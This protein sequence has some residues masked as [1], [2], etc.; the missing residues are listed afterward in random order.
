MTP[1]GGR[2][3]VNIRGQDVRFV[4]ICG[5]PRPPDVAA[6][7]MGDVVN[8]QSWDGM[9]WLP[10]TPD[11]RV[12][13]TLTL[14]ED[15]RLR[16]AL[17]G[18]LDSGLSA[19]EAPVTKDGTTTVSFTER[20]MERAGVY[21]RVLGLVGQKAYTLED[22]FQA[23]RSGALFG[24]LQ[25]QRLVVGQVFEGVHFEP[26]EALEFSKAYA[27][28][29]YLAYWVMESGL[30]ESIEFTKDDD[31]LDQHSATT[32]RVKPL[33]IKTCAAPTGAAVSLGQSYGVAG[34]NVLERKLTQDFYVSV[35]Y[36]ER[37]PLSRLLEQLSD[38]QDLVAI[39]TGRTPGYSKL[40]LRHPDVVHNLREKQY[41]VPIEMLATWQVEHDATISSLMHH[42][43]F[44]SLP[45]LGGIA[46][47][48]RWLAVT[49]VHRSPLG[50]VMA[51]R[52][53]K[54][55]LVS[56]RVFNCAAALEAYD[57]EKYGDDVTFAARV[58]RTIDTAGE[59][60]SKLVADVSAWKTALKD[61]RNDVA[62][63]KAR[64]GTVSSEHFYL[65]ESTFWLFV[66]ALLRDAD[67]E[68]SAFEQIAA[69]QRYRWLQ[70]RL[71]EILP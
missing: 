50:R 38:I 52:Y 6:V 31:G 45:D 19:G 48:E 66:S 39:G 51:T 68:E 16:L 9:W 57:R 40:S 71:A 47:V 55:M 33:P 54:T 36:G 44:F 64:M 13:G 63:H 14:Q 11:E 42:D 34:D 29:D 21:S 23:R 12:A 3:R 58:Q 67:A 26:G 15:G 18:A 53:S 25:S 2:G 4:T 28:M 17:I 49:A 35:S 32:L 41:D 65:A 46:A 1:I 24:G 43:M 62:H 37:Q 7:T 30:E 70:R 22:C 69:H 56:D 8:E 27:W 59:P 10:E 61:A 20:S 5:I 60:F